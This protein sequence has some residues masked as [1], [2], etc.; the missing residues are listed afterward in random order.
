MKRTHVF[1]GTALLCLVALCFGAG[2]RAAGSEEKA[3]PARQINYLV[4]FDPGGQSDREARRQQPLLEKY[5]GQ[6]V[7]IDYKIGGGGALGWRE[8]TRAKPDGYT[9]AGFNIPHVIL[10]PLQQDVGYKTEQIVPV[11]IFHKTPLALAVLATSPYKTIQELI[12]HAKK[13]PGA[14]TVGGSG[15]FSGYHM[16]TLR[17]EKLIGAKLTY[18]PFTGAAPQMTNFLGGHV[19]AVFGA[20]DDLTRYK[21]KVRVL[22]FATEKRFPGFPDS[23]TLK[24]QGFDMVE[25]VD[26]GIAVPPNTPPAVIKKLESAFLDIAKRPEF[27]EEQRKGGFVPLAMGHEEVK[28]YMKKMTALYTELAKGLKK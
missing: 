2:V 21:D 22:G 13:N 8:L 5:L 11:F 23:P 26:R 17:F 10:Q 6:K 9:I 15:S 24:E 25:G 28:A 18:V 7:I 12:D 16:A 14:V 27:Q 3:Y 1:M 20:S 4:C 19:V